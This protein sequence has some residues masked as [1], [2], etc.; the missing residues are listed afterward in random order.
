VPHSDAIDRTVRQ[1]QQRT[2]HAQGIDAVYRSAMG[3]MPFW[4]RIRTWHRLKH[5]GLTLRMT[6]LLREVDRVRLQKAGYFIL[7]RVRPK[8]VDARLG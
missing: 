7:R 3:S 2:G 5:S 6:E 1:I 8:W 4:A